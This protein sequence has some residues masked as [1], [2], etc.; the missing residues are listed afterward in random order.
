MTLQRLDAIVI[1]AA[2][3]V[4]LPASAEVYKLVDK[5][6]NVTYSNEPPPKSFEGEVTVVDTTNQTIVNL[7]GPQAT[8][9]RT[10]NPPRRVVATSTPGLAAARAKAAAARQAFENARDNPGADDWISH[11][12]L[13]NGATRGPSPAYLE[14]LARLQQEAI[15]AERKVTELERAAAR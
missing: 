6:G 11:A 10:P 2:L 1:A 7:Q 8:I 15:D 12:P 5:K 14:R 4:A 3:A 9:T 13:P